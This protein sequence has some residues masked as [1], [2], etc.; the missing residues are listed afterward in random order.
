MNTT[1]KEVR[2]GDAET[3]K[4]EHLILAPGGVPKRLPIPGKDLANVF[5][6]RHVQDAQKI[7]A[8]CTEGTRVAVI[9]SSFISMELV[10]TLSKKKLKTID[11]IGMEEVPFESVLGR[12][13]GDGLM[14]VGLHM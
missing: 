12:E 13:I 6:L 3:L 7:Y 2:I 4:Y 1:G 14:K 10:V 9:G 11:V 8:T 5:T